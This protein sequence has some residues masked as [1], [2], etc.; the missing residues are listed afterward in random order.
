MIGVGSEVI[1]GIAVVGLSDGGIIDEDTDAESGKTI[2]TMVR[3]GEAEGKGEPNLGGDHARVC[4]ERPVKRRG[5]VIDRVIIPVA[6]GG[7][8]QAENR[9]VIVGHPIVDV[10]V[11]VTALRIVR[12]CIF[13]VEMDA[14]IAAGNGGFQLP[15]RRRASEIIRERLT[16]RLWRC[17]RRWCRGLS[18][19]DS[20]RYEECHNRDES[21]RDLR[22]D[23]SVGQ[24][25]LASKDCGFIKGGTARGRLAAFH[26][27]YLTAA[28]IE[29]QPQTNR[30]NR[31][32]MNF[33]ATGRRELRERHS[34]MG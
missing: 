22:S 28:V 3:A 17:G 29:Q 10:C 16:L 11:D 4:V 34:H 18:R 9:R 24:S 31:Q 20:A 19:R 23:E 7:D 21:G 1:V 2:E 5:W 15:I 27:L 6:G 12:D 33:N 32:A 26:A 25:H 30:L 8:T 13:A 14:G